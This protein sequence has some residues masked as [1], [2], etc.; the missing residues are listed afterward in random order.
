MRCHYDEQSPLDLLSVDGAVI[1]RL[2]GSAGRSSR[3][4]LELRPVQVLATRGATTMTNIR[5]VDQIR[6]VLCLMATSISLT[7]GARGEGADG[8]IALERPQF[9]VQTGHSKGLLDIA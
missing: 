3:A 4:A 8:K 7:K 1:S 2:G 5:C 9:I 6:V